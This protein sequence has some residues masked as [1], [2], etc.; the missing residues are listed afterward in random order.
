MTRK[1]GPNL[2]ASLRKERLANGMPGR[3][4]KS[5][6]DFQFQSRN[7]GKMARVEGG[8]GKTEVDGGGADDHVMGADGQALLLQPDPNSSINPGR[9]KVERIDGNNFD[10]LFHECA[11]PYSP[12]LGVG[13][14]YAVQQFGHG[15]RA[16]T[17]GLR[18]PAGSEFFKIQSASFRLDDDAGIKDHS[19]A[20]SRGGAGS[21][22]RASSIS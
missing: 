19:H 2:P 20:V 21:A 7:A 11:A 3:L 9:L 13:S 14:M 8:D 1:K 6:Q 17:E 16:Q 4:I 12:D 5:R 18:L 15:N 10:D 22:A